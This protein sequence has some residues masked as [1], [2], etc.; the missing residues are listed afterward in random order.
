MLLLAPSPQCLTGRLIAIRCKEGHL[1]PFWQ[2]PSAKSRHSF[3]FAGDGG[4]QL[5]PSHRAEC[6]GWLDM[7]AEKGDGEEGAGK[8]EA[9]I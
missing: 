6:K 9:T 2:H 5:P 7:T 8:G 4:P 3:L 1:G